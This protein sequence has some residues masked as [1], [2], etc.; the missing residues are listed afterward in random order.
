MKA[1][2]C[3]LFLLVFPAFAIAQQRSIVDLKDVDFSSGQILTLDQEWEFYWNEH[4]INTMPAADLLVKPGSWNDLEINGKKCGS[5]GFATY[6]TTLINL[7]DHDLV[8]DCYSMQTAYR[9][10]INGVQKFEVGKV[11]ANEADAEPMNR[12]EQ[13][14]IPAG[15]D[16]V[17]IVIHAS[18]YHHRKGGFVHPFR[19]GRPESIVQQR[20][21]YFLLDSIESSALAIIGLFLFALYIFRRKDLSILYFALFCVTLSARPLISVNYLVGYVF[22]DI[23]WSLM[24]KVEYLA[25]FFPCLFMTLY[26]RELFTNQLPKLIVRLLVVVF[27]IKILV[28]LFFP[29]AVFSWLV[30]SILITVPIG[31]LILTVTIIRAVMA[32]VEGA[33]YAGIGV[34]VLFISLLLK[35]MSYSGIIPSVNVLITVLDIAFI[36]MMSL[37]LGSRFS[38]QFVKVET[39]QEQTEKQN[40]EIEQKKIEIEQKKKQVEK[41]KELVE[42][43]NKEIMDSINYA[44][45]IQA[46]ILPPA[47]L[48]KHF[49]PESFVLYKPKDVVAGDFYWLEKKMAGEKE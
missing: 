43:K 46:A 47:R 3:L 6:R 14:I 30:L 5:Y 31:I 11:A 8:L 13:V 32:K 28:T 35:V 42:E 23:N 49:L 24:I 39:L 16:T 9:V 18:N 33:N 26:I 37:I 25:V 40:I 17:D 48:V 41:Q 45:R 19:I 34:I 29:P 36:F 10:F 44:K 21:Q 7:P 15:T 12:D 22:P 2:K 1:I 20:L 4:A 27:G 38:L